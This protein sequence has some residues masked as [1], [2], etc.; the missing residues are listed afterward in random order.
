MPPNRSTQRRPRSAFNKG[1]SLY[2]GVQVQALRGKIP[3]IVSFEHG[4]NN[5]PE[6]KNLGFTHVYLMT[7][8]NAQARDAYLPH[9]FRAAGLIPTWFDS[10]RPLDVSVR[11]QNCSS[12]RLEP[13]GRK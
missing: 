13:K 8:E 4:V 3:G 12:G 5:S 11:P 2:R 1:G 10:S 7:F 9:R 6:K